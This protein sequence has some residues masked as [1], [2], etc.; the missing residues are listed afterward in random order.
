MQVRYTGGTV[1]HAFLGEQHLPALSARQLVRK[2]TA[3]FRL[4]YIT[5]SP[6]FSICP[7]HGYLAGEHQECPFCRENG[8]VQKCLVFSRI[9]GYLR[10]VEQWNAGKQAEFKDRKL[11]DGKHSPSSETKVKNEGAPIYVS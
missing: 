8:E 10:P 4:P 7:S 3:N 5:L 9:V 6:T 1:F 2:I 11:F